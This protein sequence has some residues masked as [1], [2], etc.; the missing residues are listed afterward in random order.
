[1]QRSESDDLTLLLNR[2]SAGDRAA[3]DQAFD[4]VYARLKAIA[5]GSS[6]SVREGDTLHPTVLVH[7]AYGRLFS[8]SRSSWNDRRHFFAVAAKAMRHIVIDHA[9]ANLASKRGGGWTRVDGGDLAGAT[10]MDPITLIM[11][12]DALTELAG[13]SPRQARV[14]ELRFFAGLSVSEVATILGKSDRTV[15]LDW[16]TARAWLRERLG[17]DGE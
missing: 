6:N 11:L 9:R 3:A 13:L 16:R 14:I 5:G 4:Q 8:A 10:P 7:E 15:E 1:M 2:G 12:D 17:S